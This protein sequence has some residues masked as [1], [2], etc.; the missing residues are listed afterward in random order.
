MWPVGIIRDYIVLPQITLML[1]LINPCTNNLY[2]V[3]K[4]KRNKK[5]NHIK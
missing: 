4:Q 2:T 1:V 5:Q 3:T